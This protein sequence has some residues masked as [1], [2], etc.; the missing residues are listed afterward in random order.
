MMLTQGS[1]L[2]S[3]VHLK[4]SY[5]RWYGSS[6]SEQRRCDLKWWK[7]SGLLTVD[8]GRRAETQVAGPTCRPLTS[9]KPP[10]LEIFCRCLILNEE[11]GDFHFKA[12]LDLLML[13]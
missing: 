5:G 12:G 6:S 9:T 13:Q 8:V 2:Q 3:I 7:M 1:K 10:S 11:F 4:V